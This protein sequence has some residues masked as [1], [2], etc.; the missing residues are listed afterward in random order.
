MPYRPW[1][2]WLGRLLLI[3]LAAASGGMIYGVVLHAVT[4][5]LTTVGKSYGSTSSTIR[6]VDSPVLFIVFL[7]LE[8]AV[9]VA[10]ILATV[11]LSRL[12]FKR[13]PPGR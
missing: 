12:V 7:A 9:T 3:P 1:A 2:V 6:F 4:G 13:R 8:A 10:I 11:A 5:Q